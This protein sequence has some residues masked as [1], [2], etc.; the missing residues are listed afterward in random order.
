MDSKNS[1]RTL[2][3]TSTTP[4]RQLLGAATRKRHILPHP[5]QP[6]HTNHGAPR[7]RK[8]HQQEHWPQRPTGC[9]TT[10]PSSLVLPTAVLSEVPSLAWLTIP[11]HRAPQG[12]SVAPLGAGS[13]ERGRTYACYRDPRLGPRVPDPPQA[14]V[15]PQNAS[16]APM[17]AHWV[18][19]SLGTGTQRLCAAGAPGLALW[20]PHPL[21]TLTIS[22]NSSGAL[23]PHWESNLLADPPVASLGLLDGHC[24]CCAKW[25]CRGT[26]GRARGAMGGVG[27]GGGRP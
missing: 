19:G 9:T 16:G 4:I 11:F 1:Q 10:A 26:L 27:G 25:R 21:R 14:L 13:P 15:A 3:T 6:R 8:R 7:T 23:L 2:A 20:V 17:V 22:S 18:L 12:A 5:P 24:S